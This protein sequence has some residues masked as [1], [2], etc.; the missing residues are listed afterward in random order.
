MMS[1]PE[2][3]AA[4]GNK[5]LVL[6]V[7][8][9]KGGVGKSWAAVGLAASSAQLGYQTVLVDADIGMANLHTLLGIHAPHKSIELFVQ[10][11][12]EALA[13]L[14]LPIPQ[15][16]G[17]Y[18]LPGSNAWTEAATF[19][20]GQK[21]R[22]IR[23]FFGLPAEVVVLDLGAGISHLT[24]D[25]WNRAD[26]QIVVC[27]RHMTSLQNAYGFLKAG[28]YRA[29]RQ[30]A[31][32]AERKQLL[33]SLTK[34]KSIE[35]I[36]SLLEEVRHLEPDLADGILAHLHS[37]RLSLLGNRIQHGMPN[38]RVFALARMISD[39]LQVSCTVLP[40]IPEHPVDDSESLLE[41]LLSGSLLHRA[42]T[43]GLHVLLEDDSVKMEGVRGR[44]TWYGFESEL[45]ARTRFE[46]RRAVSIK[47]SV[48]TRD[49][50]ADARVIDISTSG[51]AVETSLPLHPGEKVI[52]KFYQDGRSATRRATVRNSPR[53][54]VFGVRF[55]DEAIS[56][57]AESDAT[58]RPL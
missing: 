52:I 29:I 48:V 15:I 30:K 50:H 35:R 58:P 20:H 6:A 27:N 23:A 14:L 34:N 10:R 16:D 36:A 26:Q 22:L 7:G 25:F 56:G 19:N 53:D 31:E 2:G 18:L 55:E 3:T 47:A 54:Q 41:A 21:N 39:F 40:T 57:V 9:G 11:Q 5:P 33:S 32:G 43:D 42:F 37:V 24:L 28:V 46:R 4:E 13:E 45:H 44:S 1:S 12:E 38:E 51:A 8:G 49:Q 17:L